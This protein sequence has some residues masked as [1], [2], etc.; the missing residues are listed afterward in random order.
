MKEALAQ[1]FIVGLILFFFGILL[2]LYFGTLNY[3]KAFKAKNRIITILE[4]YGDITTDSTD[5]KKITN[6]DVIPEIEK[7]LND[8]GYQ[9]VKAT[10]LE[11][12]CNDLAKSERDGSSEG[13]VIYPTAAESSVGRSYDFCLIERDSTVGP[14]YQVVAYMKFDVP[15]IGGSLIFPVRGETKVLCDNIELCTQTSN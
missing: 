12:R 9:T 15:L 7:N 8:G 13:R 2:I 14:Y 4:K 5:P 11:R 10:N 3:S 6:S 1:T